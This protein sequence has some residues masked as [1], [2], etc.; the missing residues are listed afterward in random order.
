MNNKPIAVDFDGVLHNMKD[1]YD[2][3]RPTGK[4]IEDAKWAM[5]HL[6]SK[7]Y[8]LIVFTTRQEVGYVGEWLEKN[9]IP[10]DEV[11]NKKPIALAYIDDRGIR[12]T[13]WEDI[14]K[15]FV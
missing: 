5:S 10:Y 7:G 2:G 4:P 11:T 13:N 9:R 12:F 1:G 6:K 8:I 3:A 14:V 15:Y